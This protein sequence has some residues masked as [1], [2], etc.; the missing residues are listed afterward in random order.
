METIDIILCGMALVSI[1][2]LAVVFGLMACS[3]QAKEFYRK[4][5]GCSGVNKE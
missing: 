5:K 4:L 2:G 1:C 3:D